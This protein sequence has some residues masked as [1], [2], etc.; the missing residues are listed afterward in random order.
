M[1]DLRIKWSGTLSKWN[2]LVWCSMSSQEM[3]LAVSTHFLNHLFSLTNT[4]YHN[5]PIFCL[6]DDSLS[7]VWL[8]NCSG[9]R[10]FKAFWNIGYISIYS[11]QWTVALSF[12]ICW[13]LINGLWLHIPLKYLLL[14]ILFCNT[15]FSGLQIFPTEHGTLRLL[16]SLCYYINL[17]VFIWLRWK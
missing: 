12:Y 1:A 10:S 15:Y 14:E 9:A 17:K 7:A 2:L 6:L 11:T 4:E 16:H 13:S 3:P 5:P 8:W